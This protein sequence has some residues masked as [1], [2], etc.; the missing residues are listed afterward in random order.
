MWERTR[1]GGNGWAER[2]A[3]ARGVPSTLSPILPI[4]RI[5]H[6]MG[7]IILFVIVMSIGFIYYLHRCGDRRKPLN[8][9]L[10]ARETETWMSRLDCGSS[11]A[12]L[13]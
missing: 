1:R 12:F 13:F 3:G 8:N 7:E 9:L 6:K 4:C 5:V 2:V 10:C 11:G